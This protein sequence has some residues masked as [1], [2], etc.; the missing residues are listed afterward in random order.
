MSWIRR[1]LN[2]HPV[3]VGYLN[4]FSPV[5]QDAVAQVV[6]EI[7]G[8][9][10]D[11]NSFPRVNFVETPRTVKSKPL[12]QPQGSAVYELRGERRGFNFRVTEVDIHPENIIRRATDL[13]K[14]KDG[15]NVQ[16]K[17]REYNYDKRTMALHMLEIA[18]TQ[19]L[20]DAFLVDS[21]LNVNRAEI[22]LLAT[23]KAYRIINSD[24]T[25]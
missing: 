19:L 23:S 18:G 8:N 15:I 5:L 22:N 1:T 21:E 12:I 9:P 10:V 7:T 20:T 11:P 16:A 2:K 17:S 4:D 14:L 6:T 3:L 25:E 13:I 24:D